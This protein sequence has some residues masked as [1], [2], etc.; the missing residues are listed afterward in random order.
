[1]LLRVEDAGVAVKLPP[2][3]SLV[4]SAGLK[5]DLVRNKKIMLTESF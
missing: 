5:K 1:M 2:S 3:D 4:N